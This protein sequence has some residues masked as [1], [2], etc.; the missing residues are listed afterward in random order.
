MGKKTSSSSPNA[1]KD[2]LNLSLV[3][4]TPR[5]TRE[6]GSVNSTARNTSRKIPDTDDVSYLKKPEGLTNPLAVGDI[7]IKKTQ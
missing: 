5:Q 4:G 1:N 7:T 6:G 3:V 2:L